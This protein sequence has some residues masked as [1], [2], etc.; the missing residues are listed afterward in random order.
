M[1]AVREAA[2]K[3]LHVLEDPGSQPRGDRH[4]RVPAAYE[5]GAKTVAVYPYEDRNSL[6]RLKADEAYQIGEPGHPVRAY[7]DVSTRSSASP[8]SPAPTRSTPATGSSPRTPSW[9]QAAAETGITFIGPP[10]QVLEMAG[11]KVTAKEH[12]IAAGVPVLQVDAAVARHRRARRQAD[13]IGFP[14]FAKAVAGGGGRGMRRVEHEGRPPRRARRGDAR[15]RQRVRRP[16]DV[17]RAGGA[18]PA[19]HRGADP[20]GRHRAR[21]CTCSSATARCSAATR[22]SS[23]SRPRRTSPT[24]V[25]QALYRDAIA[26]AKSIGYVNAGT[27]EFLLD[28]VGERAGQHVFIEMNPRIQVE[29]TVTEEVTDVDLV[30][31]ADAHRR[32]GDPRRPRPRAGRTSACAARRCSAASPPRTRRQGSGPTP[33]RSRPTAR[34][35]APASASTAAP[36]TPG[37]RSARTSTRC[38]P[39]SPAAGATTRPRSPARSAPSPSSASAASPRTS[40]SCRPCSR[41]RRSSRATSAPRSSTSGPQ[42][43]RGRVSKDRGTKILNWLADVTVNQPNGPAP[44]SVNPADKLPAID[45]SDA[46]PRRLAPAAAGARTGRVRRGAARADAA[47]GHRDHLPRRAPVAARDPRAHAGPRRGRAV[48]RADDARAALGRGVGRRDL[49]RRA[50]LPRRGPVGAARRR[51]A[52]RCRT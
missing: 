33:A 34:P 15:G 38:S 11:N 31:V 10:K 2:S 50:P 36:S 25:R 13:E 43:L 1:F 28:T 18:A 4:P 39:S 19:P 17:P 5:L 40:R 32:G 7:L 42:L 12:A 21:R 37:R 27:V 9:P 6:H 49:R 20:G 45:L 14:I 24:S 52:R 46:R 26:F 30:R 8:A 48:R 44:T 51:C 35:A 41:I 16:D 47:R 23:R 22:R 3:G 29:H